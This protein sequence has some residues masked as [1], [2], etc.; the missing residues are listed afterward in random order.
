M[1]DSKMIYLIFVTVFNVAFVTTAKIVGG[2]ML[3]KS[4]VNYFEAKAQK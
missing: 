4:I 2:R 1:S 3:E